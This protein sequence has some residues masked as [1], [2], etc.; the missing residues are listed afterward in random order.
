M[1]VWE[2]LKPSEGPSSNAD[3]I[4]RATPNFQREIIAN[5]NLWDLT[6]IYNLMTTA[7]RSNRGNSVEL[8]DWGPDD[9]VETGSCLAQACGL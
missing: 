8:T 2:L 4:L 3:S 7:S 1:G 6:I 5:C 9:G